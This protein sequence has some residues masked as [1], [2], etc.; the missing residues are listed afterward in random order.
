M[1]SRLLLKYKSLEQVNEA[2]RHQKIVLSE[3]CATVSK[4][5]KPIEE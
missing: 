2:L 3:N 4:H 1:Y 5:I